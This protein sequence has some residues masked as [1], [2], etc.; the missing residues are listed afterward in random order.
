MVALCV[1]FTIGLIN[2]ALIQAINSKDTR[3]I[4]ERLED[5]NNQIEDMKK[6]D[7]RFGNFAENL[8]NGAMD[9]RFSPTVMR[10]FVFICVS[11]P[12]LNVIFLIGF[13]KDLLA[14]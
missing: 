14:D 11:L 10:L 5:V 8:F 12:F 1:C 2:L 7:E 13:L 9:G 3:D 4:F 6:K